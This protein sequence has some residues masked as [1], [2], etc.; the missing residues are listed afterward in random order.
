MSA[1]VADH[2]FDRV[3]AALRAR[4]LKVRELD[5]DRAKA[6]CPSHSD[7]SR[8][9]LSVTRDP[10]KVLMHCFGGCARGAPARALGF[11]LA[12]LFVGGE[13]PPRPRPTIVT[14]YTFE[15]RSDGARVE[16]TRM[17][18]KSFPWRSPDPSARSGWRWGLA[19]RKVSDLRIYRFPQL[20]GASRLWI[21]E[22]EKSA[23]RLAATGLAA[24]C[25]AAGASAWAGAWTDD[26]LALGCR[27]VV[28]LPD[29]D[30]VGERH[31]ERIATDLHARGAAIVVRIARLPDVPVSGDVFD[32]LETRTR[33]ALE[34]IADA[35]PI[36][37]PNAAARRRAD[38]KRERQ[39][40]RAACWRSRQPQTAT[41]RVAR[42]VA[43]GAA[44]A[45][46]VDAIGKAGGSASG[47]QIKAALRANYGR[48]LVDG[49][50]RDGRDLGVLRTVAGPR[51][52]RVHSV[53]NA[54]HSAP[55]DLHGVTNDGHSDPATD[56]RSVMS[57]RTLGDPAGHSFSNFSEEKGSVR[58]SGNAERANAPE[59][60]FSSLTDE[61][62]PVTYERDVS[63]TLDEGIT[64]AW[65]DAPVPNAVR[66]R[67]DA[68]A[69]WRGR[70]PGP[71]D[72]PFG[73]SPEAWQRHHG[74]KLRGHAAKGEAI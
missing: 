74:G 49:A 33:A 22:G 57:V 14:R 51:G 27:D 69:R 43:R 66:V 56:I 8:D 12:D 48:D 7:R 50:L 21:A 25:G 55:T 37:T 42:A 39:R 26:V 17:E 58:P 46:A 28:I 29:N 30:Q 68:D 52:A 23:D 5:A 64:E 72:P 32:F 45:A 65:T 59:R 20:A 71:N 47:R 40:A 11:A 13:R 3:L 54:G 36:W 24:T 44:L 15:M 61:V 62:T 38:A 10:M 35:T 53:T 18:P 60:S 4:G 9:S 16:K 19:G 70:V 1:A 2:P 6:E 63:R 73:I 31:A 67:R 34:E 41:P